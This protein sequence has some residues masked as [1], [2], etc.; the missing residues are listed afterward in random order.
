MPL[1]IKDE[2]ETNTDFISR[3]AVKIADEFPSMEQ[4]IAVCYSQLKKSELSKEEEKDTFVL[5]P[6]RKENRGTYLKRCSSNEK[7]REALPFMKERMGY[8]LN[9]YSEYYRWWGKFEDGEPSP[10]SA[11]GLC[12]ANGRASG[13]TYREAYARCA[14]KSVS[15][16]TTIVLSEEDDLLIEPVED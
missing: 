10:E 15:P 11:L 1:P 4:R 5:Q 13:L 2:K 12:I 8:C 6:R 7:M 14:T 16:N 3:C 9:A